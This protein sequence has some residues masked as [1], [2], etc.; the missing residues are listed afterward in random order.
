M[1][2]LLAMGLAIGVAACTTT[3][4]TPP[5][6]AEQAVLT[7]GDLGAIG[8]AAILTEGTPKQVA[9]T[10]LAVGAAKAILASE[11]P[12]LLA[13]QAA[14]A[15]ADLDPRW[16]A[17]SR[18]VLQRIQQRL[19]STDPIP[20]DSPAFGVAQAFVGACGDVLGQAA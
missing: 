11:T 7:A 10:R 12:T 5:T 9:T 13:L 1:R 20:R 16:R 19:G 8:C 3:G 15:A 4:G 14:F 2:M 18:V 6:D 17:L